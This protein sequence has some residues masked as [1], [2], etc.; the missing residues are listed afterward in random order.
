MM[1]CTRF[2]LRAAIVL[3]MFHTAASFFR[4]RSRSPVLTRLRTTESVRIAAV[5]TFCIAALGARYCV[6]QIITDDFDDGNDTNPKSPGR[7]VRHYAPT[8]PLR[9]NAEAVAVDEVLLA[10]GPELLSGAVTTK[11]LSPTGDLAEAAANLFAMLHELDAC[12][13]TAIAAMAIPDHGLGAAIND[14][15]RR[16]AAA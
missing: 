7:L 6:A 4:R 12:G 11:N 1:S 5:L 8:T 16:A 10:F 14:R 15:L 2:T 9:L 13:A 3:A